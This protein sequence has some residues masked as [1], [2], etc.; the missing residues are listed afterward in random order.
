MGDVKALNVLSE[1]KSIAG[2][3]AELDGMKV[4]LGTGTTVAEWYLLGDVT[5]CPVPGPVD[6]L[7]AERLLSASWWSSSS[8]CRSLWCCTW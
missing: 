8:C 4:G 2:A 5:D 3:A 1:K 6:V 7:Q